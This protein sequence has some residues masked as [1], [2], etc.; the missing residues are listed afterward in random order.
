MTPPAESAAKSV[1]RD[2][3]RA[4]R[5]GLGENERAAASAAIA[6]RTIAVVAAN[7]PAVLAAYSA[8]RSEVDPD[9][10]IAWALANG[11]VVA[12]PAV[13]DATTLV[14]RRYAP[15]DPL[16]AGGYGTLAPTRDAPEVHP[17]LI[18]SPLLAFDRKGSRLGYGR[19]FYDRGLWLLRARGMKPLS[20][21]LAFATQEVT[22]IPD[23]LHDV[24]MDWI[25]TERETLDLGS[26][27]VK[28]T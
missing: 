9:E 1:L 21:G 20:I 26:P 11:L 22:A 2:A 15:G 23:E 24:R 25:V 12:L 5:D 4:R 3:A 18:V 13:V 28:G 17:D 10:I 16:A 14:F 19:G 6:E 27:P 8:I 7:R